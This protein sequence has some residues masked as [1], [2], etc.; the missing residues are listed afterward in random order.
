MLLPNGETASGLAKKVGVPQPT[1]S[2]WARSFGTVSLVSNKN[3]TGSASGSRRPEDWSAQQRLR[4]VTEA[5]RLS[6]EGLGEF[7]RR[8]G[9]H[10][11]V[12]TEWRNAALEGLAPQRPRQRGDKKRIDKLERD[13]ARKEKQLKAS[14]A[15][16]ELS[17]KMH[18]LWA[19]KDGVTPEENDK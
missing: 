10:E 4:V 15:L 19:E 14:E 11:E 7:L 18:A 9:L 16:V 5:A 13:L 8:E 12:L 17:K 6:E 1:L 2:R 3:M